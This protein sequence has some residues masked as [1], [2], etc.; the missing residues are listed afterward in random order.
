MRLR[1]PC[2]HHM[3]PVTQ[4]QVQAQRERPP[5]R[6]DAMAMLSRPNTACN[7]SVLSSL[8]LPDSA[9]SFDVLTPIAD[10][11]FSLWT[12]DV[13]CCDCLRTGC[14]DALT[15]A[16]TDATPTCCLSAG[17]KRAVALGG[18]RLTCQRASPTG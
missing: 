15:T 2:R 5:H 14:V 3:W 18:Q 6:Q 12:P 10:A 11:F 17:G 13:K 16:G 8:L 9:E 4:Q 7:A 1:Q